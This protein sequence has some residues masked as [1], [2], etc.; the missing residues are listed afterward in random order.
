MN[1]ECIGNKIVNTMKQLHIS[2]KQLCEMTNLS[3]S[4]IYRL[5]YSLTQNPSAPTL[6]RISIALNLPIADLL[7]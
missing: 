4:T 3:R 6:E 2:Q 7:N 5:S 1:T